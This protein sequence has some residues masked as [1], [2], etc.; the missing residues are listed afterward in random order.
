MAVQVTENE[1]TADLQSDGQSQN[2][3]VCLLM[4]QQLSDEADHENKQNHREED[5]EEF[6]SLHYYCTEQMGFVKHA[7]VLSFYFLLRAQRRKNK[8]GGFFEHVLRQVVAL[9]GDSDTNAMIVMGMVGAL[10]GIKEVPEAML[11]KLLE[12]DCKTQQVQRPSFLSVRENALNNIE[13]LI[14]LRPLQKLV[15]VETDKSEIQDLQQA[16]K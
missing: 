9:A 1:L 7:F 15:I 13:A 6:L 2:C 16:E 4:A 12:F 10:V 8:F 5:D 14:S 11:A 3:F